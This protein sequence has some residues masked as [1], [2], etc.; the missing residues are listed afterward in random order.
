M[1]SYRNYKADACQSA[2][3]WMAAISTLGGMATIIGFFNE[4]PAHETIG[5][6]LVAAVCG[7]L[8]GLAFRAETRWRR[9]K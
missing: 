2:G 6:L 8:A 9:I 3:I 7:T 1:S 5:S 4:W